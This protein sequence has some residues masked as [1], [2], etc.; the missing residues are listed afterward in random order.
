MLTGLLLAYFIASSFSLISFADITK[1]FKDGAVHPPLYKGSNILGLNNGVITSVCNSVLLGSNPLAL[2]T[3]V[4]GGGH[5][6]V[7]LSD[8]RGTLLSGLPNIDVVRDEG[9]V[10]EILKSPQDSDLWTRQTPKIKA[11]EQV[12]GGSLIMTDGVDWKMDRAGMMIAFRNM[13]R[14]TDPMRGVTRKFIENIKVEVEKGHSNFNMDKIFSELTFR[15]LVESLFGFSLSDN[16]DLIDNLADWEIILESLNA[17][18]NMPFL[19]LTTKASKA[20]SRLDKS[21]ASIVAKR[22]EEFQ[23]AEE[24]G[25]PISPSNLM[26][27]LIWNAD[28]KRPIYN[29]ASDPKLLNQVKLFFFAGHETTALTLRWALHLLL[30]NEGKFQNLI[31]EIDGVDIPDLKHN[32]INKN[33]FP[34][35]SAVVDETLRLFPAA[36]MTMR[37]PSDDITISGTERAWKIPAGTMLLLPIFTLHRDV[38]VWGEN[39]NSFKPER[40]LSNSDR[41]SADG[42]NLA[43]GTGAR[44]CIGKGFSLM[45][46]KLVLIELLRAFRFTLPAHRRSG[47]Q[48]GRELLNPKLTLH[49]REPLLVEISIRN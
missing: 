16:P 45:E 1:G 14:F 38:R 9:L 26:D 35:L 42:C 27:V 10:T 32:D 24:S 11:M 29:S 33:N 47:T 41:E 13:D 15:I 6:V 25:Q 36:Y 34:Y 8:Y 3:A 39:A 31:E 23:A 4:Q 21:I 48:T 49:A 22:L 37:V 5:D 44:Q 19:K 28:E 43:F 17:S 2:L 12:F 46:T 7:Q 30:Q 18:F 40:H 20:N